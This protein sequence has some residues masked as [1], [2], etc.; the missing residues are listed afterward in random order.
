MI[1]TFL[2]ALDRNRPILFFTHW[3]VQEP[4]FIFWTTAVVYCQEKRT[5]WG[6]SGYRTPGDELFVAVYRTLFIASC[7]GFRVKGS[8]V[9]F[10]FIAVA[11]FRLPL[12]CPFQVFFI[13]SGIF[14][15][16]RLLVPQPKPRAR[17][18]IFQPVLDCVLEVRVYVKLF[19]GG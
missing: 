16:Y 17:D 13:C 1:C 9:L 10:V 2:V 12:H 15:Q 4:N 5:L 6:L 19:G 3:S 14:L 11:G 18:Q 8:T 7:V